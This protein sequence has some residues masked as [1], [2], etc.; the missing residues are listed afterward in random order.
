M[1]HLVATDLPSRNPFADPSTLTLADL[2]ARVRS[3]DTLSLTTRQNWA[4]ALRT[5]AR[6]AGKDPAT[7]PAHPQFL[8]KVLGRAAPKAIG[9]S[10]ASWN[11]ARSLCGKALKWAGLVSVPG[12]YLA[13]FAPAWAEL[14]ACL[15][16]ESALRH[17]LGRLFHYASA[18]GIAP[19]EINDAVLAT[20]HQALVTE[21]IVPDPS[22]TWRG[23]AKSWNNA[24]RHIPG[25]PQTRLM[26]P[27]RKRLFS[28]PWTDLPPTLAA[29]ID[30]YLRR[31]AGLDLSDD[32]F[33]AAQRPATIE[34]RRKQLRLFATA[35]AKSGVP[36]ESLVDL[37]ATLAPEVAARGLEYLLDCNGGIS[38]V[39]ISNLADFLPALARRLGLS[40]DVIA[41]LL[42]IKKKLKITQRGMTARN[43]EALRA[44][45]DQAA[46]KALMMLARRVVGDV[47]S[48]KRAGYRE[49][50]L[51]QTALAV[52]LLLNVPV[53]IQNL[54]SIE[55]ER[56]LIEVGTAGARTVHLR[57]PATEV[58][59]RNDLEFPLMPESVE[60]LDNYVAKWRP[61]MTIGPS[62][63]LFPGKTPDHNKGPQQPDQRACLRLYAPRYAGASIPAR[64]C[65]DSSRPP[66]R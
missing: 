59:N 50:K 20:F 14:W 48:G 46:V 31:A 56:H 55:L 54:A 4:W 23:A 30:S 29:D 57:F 64:G 40:S 43:R 13:P 52:E 53:R 3:A 33:T 42:K 41:K 19:N 61:L 39:Q 32:M 58:K 28:M 60:L 44:F 65:Q 27:S 15:P 34:K 21:S 51:I 47:Q 22:E 24:I 66:P 6:A 45:D 9:I 5:V 16:A 49:A 63:F 2:I 38:S 62:P 25:W 1:R 18:Q 35:L 10:Q 37:R 26:V 8:R 11:N 12:R 36:L 17:Q 7:V